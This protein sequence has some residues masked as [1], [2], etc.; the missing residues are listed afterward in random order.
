MTS[1]EGKGGLGY[2]VIRLFGCLVCC[3]MQRVNIYKVLKHNSKDT[4]DNN[5]YQ[6]YKGILLQIYYRLGCRAVFEDGK[7][8]H[9]F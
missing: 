6:A 9:A 7:A 2:L 3:Q 8:A 5:S 1:W 4:V